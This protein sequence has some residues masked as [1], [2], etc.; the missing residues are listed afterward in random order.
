MNDE[1]E[2]R[3][4]A[5]EEELQAAKQAAG[6]ATAD[7]GPLTNPEPR[8]TRHQVQRRSHTRMLIAALVLLVVAGGS[9]GGWA[10]LHRDNNPLRGYAAHSSFP[11]YYPTQIPAGYH[12]DQQHIQREAGLVSYTFKGDAKQPDLVVSLQNTPSGFDASKLVSDASIPTQVTAIGSFYD[13]STADQTKC[14]ITTGNGTLI[15][16][17]ATHKA[18]DAVV[19]TITNSFKRVN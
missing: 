12:L 10:Y 13:I 3:L 5:L 6:A 9:F 16:I 18:S 15:L 7:T 2:R 4:K 17:N 8:K 19:H 1:L 14:F 11:L